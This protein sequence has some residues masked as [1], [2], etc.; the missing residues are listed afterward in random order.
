M[1]FY[2]I[3]LGLIDDSVEQEILGFEESMRFSKSLEFYKEDGEVVFVFSEDF[4]RYVQ[5][6]VI[7]FGS[8]LLEQVSS[9]IFFKKC[10]IIFFFKMIS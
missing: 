10:K 2:V 7:L 6:D 9:K 1:E 5:K 3:F 4:E 8:F